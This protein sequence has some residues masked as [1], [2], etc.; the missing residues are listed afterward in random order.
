VI[1]SHFHHPFAQFQTLTILILPPGQPLFQ[2]YP[3]TPLT[4]LPTLSTSLCALTPTSKFRTR[5]FKRNAEAFV[6]HAIDYFLSHESTSSLILKARD[7]VANYPKVPAWL[8]RL[9]KPLPAVETINTQGPQV[10]QY[11]SS[12]TGTCTDF[13][14][15]S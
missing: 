3:L 11:L 6:A 4:L 14:N 13:P 8:N 2:C 10:I 5:F 12:L 1:T 9:T 15:L 7:V